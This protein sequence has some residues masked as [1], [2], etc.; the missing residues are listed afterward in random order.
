MVE[1]RRGRLGL[2]EEKQHRKRSRPARVPAS[3]PAHLRRS[4]RLNPNRD[5]VEIRNDD[6]EKQIGIN[7]HDEECGFNIHKHRKYE[8][9]EEDR[10]GYG[11]EVGESESE[12]E[13]PLLTGLTV[14]IPDDE[15]EACSLLAI[16]E[17][18]RRCKN[19]NE[20]PQLEFVK[21]LKATYTACD[22]L[23]FLITFEAKDIAAG[24]Q[25]K[26]YQTVVRRTYNRHGDVSVLSFRE[27]EQE[28]G[29]GGIRAEDWLWEG[30]IHPF[31]EYPSEEEIVEEDM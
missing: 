1:K 20:N 18:H 4:T 21:L 8:M 16:D 2:V 24:G 17:Y 22:M 31:V 29:S 19:Q 25:T 28:Q 6:P 7:V 10:V 27:C 14:P 12:S 15:Y 9:T 11:E 13:V 23:R 3:G 5:A 30:H 26:T